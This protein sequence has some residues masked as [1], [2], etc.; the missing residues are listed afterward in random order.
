MAVTGQVLGEA[1]RAVGAGSRLVRPLDE[2]AAGADAALRQAPPGLTAVGCASYLADKAM[3]SD[4]FRATEEYA[5]N[6]RYAPCIGRTFQMVTWEENYRQL[7]RWLNARGLLADPEAFVR[8]PPSLADYRW[9]WLGGVWFFEANGLWRYANA[10]DHWRVS[11]AVNG[12]NRKIGTS[13]TPNGWDARRKMFDA[14]RRAGAV[15][16]PGGAPAVAET[17]ALPELAEGD[18]SELVWKLATWLN[19]EF[20]KYSRINAGDRPPCRLGPQC[21]AAMTEFQR[22]TGIPTAPPFGWGPRSWEAARSLGFRP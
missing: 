4:Y 7:G 22:R 14:L 12:G 8:N 5:K 18:T 19:R 6:G 15:L 16:L 9:A 1:L 11:Q 21:M 10:G 20:P 3:E 17:G 2:L 13:F